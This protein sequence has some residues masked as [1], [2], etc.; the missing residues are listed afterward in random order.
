MFLEQRRQ[1]W[2]DVDHLTHSKSSCSKQNTLT[3]I[4]GAK[5]NKELFA[6]QKSKTEFPNSNLQREKN[7]RFIVASQ[8]WTDLLLQYAFALCNI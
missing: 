2:I 1:W 3:G 8:N 4:R 7:T 5:K 6:E